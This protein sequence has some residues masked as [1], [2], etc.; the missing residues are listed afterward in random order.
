MK[1]RTR[2]DNNRKKLVLKRFLIGLGGVVVLLITALCIYLATY[3][4]AGNT[5]KASLE[6]VGSVRV[7]SRSGYILFDGFSSENLLVFYPGARVEYTAYA[8]LMRRLAGRGIDCALVKMPFNFA[9]LKQN[10]F[11]DVMESLQVGY[12][13]YEHFYIGGHSM[14]GAMAAIYAANNPGKVEALI[15]LAAYP[16]KALPN[17]LK[18][19][20]IYGSNDSVINREK[21]SESAQY[22]PEGAVVY[23]IVGGNH[24]QFGDY[25]KQGGDGEAGITTEKQLDETIDQIA[26]LLML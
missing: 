17:D 5:A 6:S 7:E 2:V 24:A 8:P 12:Q 15:M 13:P 14:G 4:R 25:G 1:K 18:V 3:Y 16:T 10:A 21:L 26:K 22:L 11:D 23:E 20:E 19:L 9:I